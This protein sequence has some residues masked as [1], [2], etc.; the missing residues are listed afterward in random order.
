MINSGALLLLIA[1]REI[2]KFPALIVYLFNSL[3]GSL[4]ICFM[5]F[6]ILLLDSIDFQDYYDFLMN[7][8][9][10]PYR[11]Y[12]FISSNSLYSEVYFDI[13]SYSNFLLIYDLCFHGTHFFIFSLLIN[14]NLYIQYGFLVIVYSQILYFNLLWHSLTF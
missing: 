2:L 6:D 14:I 12:L 3:S 4:S 11:M 7:C 5:Y 10:P 8:T 9:F 1:E 13:C